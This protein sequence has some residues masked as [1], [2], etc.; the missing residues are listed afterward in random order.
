M[1]A[2]WKADIKR[3]WHELD[4]KDI[5]IEVANGDGYKQLNPK[6]L[7]LKVGSQ[8]RVSALVRLGRIN[9]ADISVELYHGPVDANGNIYEG[10]VVK[11]DCSQNPE[12]DSQYWFIG[13]LPCKRTGQHGLDVRILP[14]HPDLS[15]PYELH[16]ILWG[17][18][19]VK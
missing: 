10:S 9:P 1:F 18:T 7:Q 16:L 12:K 14:R 17:N 4:V 19:R 15:N 8:L 2:G 11:M 13:S 6:Q 3:A 5:L